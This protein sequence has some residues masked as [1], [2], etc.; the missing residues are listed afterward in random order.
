MSQCYL[1]YSDIFWHKGLL[2]LCKSI[3]LIRVTFSSM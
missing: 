2:E 1:L 3:V